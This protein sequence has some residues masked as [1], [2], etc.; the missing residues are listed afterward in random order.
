MSLFPKYW[1]RV[2]MKLMILAVHWG[3]PRLMVKS[4]SRDMVVAFVT[5]LVPLGGLD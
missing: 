2:K 4:F 1:M 3:L 5:G